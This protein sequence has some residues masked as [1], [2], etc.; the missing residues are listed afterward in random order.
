MWNP[1]RACAKGV[2]L[3]P[4]GVARSCANKGL[5]LS[6][7]HKIRMSNG[8]RCSIVLSSAG[9]ADSYGNNIQRKSESGF[10]SVRSCLL[11][12]ADRKSSY[13]ASIFIHAKENHPK[14]LR[15]ISS[16]TSRVPGLGWASAK[17]RG[18]FLIDEK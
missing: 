2:F 17:K 10:I 15:C 5:L 7:G 18:F 1:L 16:S 3:S 14:D 6:Y 8:G 11:S 9:A 4:E 12:S 13:I